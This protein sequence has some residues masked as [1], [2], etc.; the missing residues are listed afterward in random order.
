MIVVVST[1]T[2]LLPEARSLKDRRSVLR[3]LKDRLRKLNLSVA[4]VGDQDRW[5]HARLAV[6]L[7]AGDR[8]FADSVLSQ[9][10]R[11]LE[12]EHR[13]IITSVD[14]FDA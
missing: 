2:L 9:A 10:D 8:G 12:S 4:D 13:I 5:G 3:S 6:A 7:V 1:W 11:I 14:R